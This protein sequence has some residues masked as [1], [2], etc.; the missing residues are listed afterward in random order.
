MKKFILAALALIMTA[1]LQPANAQLMDN[2]DP[3][4]GFTYE[5]LQEKVLPDASGTNRYFYNLQV[6]AYY[7]FFHRNDQVSVGVDPGLQVG[8]RP[9]ATSTNFV[10]DYRINVPV[11]L[12]A[13]AG[14][15]AT[16]Y[17]TQKVGIGV[18]IG[19]DYTYFSQSVNPSVGLR[20]STGYI[21]PAAAVQIAVRTR[22][23]LVTVRFHASL[24]DIESQ[25]K[26]NDGGSPD[27]RFLRN[28]GLG[29]L[30]EF[31]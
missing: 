29:I 24:A 16:R 23:N 30:Y 7:T 15:G 19:G 25:F 1:A 27:T 13:R 9:L 21:T 22:Q 18:G 31:R 8:I 26:Y 5:L 3:Y 6:G 20:R 17:N 28:F 2:L 4:M 10:V 14:A 11:Y 12:M